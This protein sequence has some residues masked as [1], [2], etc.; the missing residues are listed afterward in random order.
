MTSR[1]SSLPRWRLVAMHLS[2]LAE[3]LVLWC[4]AEFGFASMDDAYSTGSSIMPQKKNPDVAELVRG[5]TGRVYGNL[6]ALLTVLKGLPLSYNRDLQE[7]KALYFESID[8]VHACLQLSAEMIRTLEPRPDACVRP[9]AVVFRPRPTWPTS[10]SARACR[11]AR[12]T[13]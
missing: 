8:S 5:R 4:S 3:E 9:P 12:R 2:R 1:S 11:S 7:D 13:G 10:W 6:A